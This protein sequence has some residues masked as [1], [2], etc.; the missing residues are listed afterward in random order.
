VHRLLPLLTFTTVDVLGYRRR[1]R[2]TLRLSYIEDLVLRSPQKRASRRTATGRSVRGHPSRRLASRSAAADLDTYEV[3][4]SG[5][6]DFGARLDEVIGYSRRL[7]T[8]FL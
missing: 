7:A 1:S 6:P 2:D 4:K 5:R 3:P 8:K